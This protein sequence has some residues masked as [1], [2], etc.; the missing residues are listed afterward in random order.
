MDEKGCRLTIR[1]Q[2]DILAEKGVK[3]VHIIA[4]EHAEKVTIVECVNA[5]GQA[6]PP[7]I[8]Y[9]CKNKK[10]TYEDNL[11][12]GSIVTMSKK[13]SMTVKVFNI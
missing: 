13:G 11:L 2:Q 9:K 1:H 8:I 3:R 4:N 12:P 5:I 6:V 10:A 7:M